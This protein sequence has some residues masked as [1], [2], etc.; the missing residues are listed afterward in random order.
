MQLRRR[1]GAEAAVTAAAD[2]WHRLPQRAPG[3]SRMRPV[4]CHFCACRKL[5][6]LAQQVVEL[7]AA[8][9][10]LLTAGGTAQ[11]ARRQHPP[12]WL[13]RIADQIAAG[14]IAAMVCM[15]LEEQLGLDRS[16]AFRMG[17]AAGL[18][19][20]SGHTVLAALLDALKFHPQLDDPPFR[21]TLYFCA[22]AQMGA[23]AAFIDMGVQPQAA[24][25]LAASVGRPQVL[26]PWLSTVTEALLFTF[27]T[28]DTGGRRSHM[29]HS[30]GGF[31]CNC[32]PD[33]QTD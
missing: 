10:P 33:R 16:D 2:D 28:G 22:T 31:P 30:L 12:E 14:S 19:L 3:S 6:A 8:L 24:S 23:M 26:L 18:V 25:A 21:R 32:L 15:Q 11:P 13:R 17:T 4:A 27:E 20:N 5:L 7:D 9:L 29:Q 1:P